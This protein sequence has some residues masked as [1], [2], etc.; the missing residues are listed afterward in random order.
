MMTTARMNRRQFFGELGKSSLIIGFSLSPMA[1]SI[2]AQEAQAA[3]L[4]SQL[5]VLT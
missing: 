1:A 2:L 4:D 5:T 3:S